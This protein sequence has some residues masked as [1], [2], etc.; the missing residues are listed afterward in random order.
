MRAVCR[1]FQRSTQ[2][3]H[4]SKLALHARHLTL[5][6]GHS[7]VF[8]RHPRT[9]ARDRTAARCRAGAAARAQRR[10]SSVAELGPSRD[11]LAAVVPRAYTSVTEY[12]HICVSIRTDDGRRRGGRRNGRV[13]RSIAAVLALLA[14]RPLEDQGSASRPA[15]PRV[16]E[17]RSSAA[18]QRCVRIL[19]AHADCYRSTGQAP[20]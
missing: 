6:P 1:V 5:Q 4:T 18:A 17:R 3:M 8:A 2:V 15:G 20:W 12:D 14:F 9:R 7:R 13:R 10:S 11:V 16:S 19:H